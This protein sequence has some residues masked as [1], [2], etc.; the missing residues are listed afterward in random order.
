MHKILCMMH[1]ITFFTKNQSQILAIL[2]SQM[3]KEYSLSELGEIIK[4]HPGVFKRGI[5]S[6][7]KQNIILGRKSGNQRLFKINNKNL[8]FNEIKG[9]IEKS[10]GIRGLLSSLIKNI[11]GINIALIYGSYASVKMRADSDIDLLIVVNTVKV[12]DELMD[13]LKNAERRLQREI[14]YKMYTKNEFQAKLKNKDPF[15]NEV[16]GSQYILLKGEIK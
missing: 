3:D 9:I 10:V 8:F 7:C 5:D 16:L 6:L 14:N 13:K 15:L 1:K 4:K 11:K 2:L 12:E